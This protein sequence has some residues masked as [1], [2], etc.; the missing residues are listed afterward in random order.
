MFLTMTQDST[1]KKL[2]YCS[3]T[4]ALSQ[5]SSEIWVGIPACLIA[6]LNTSGLMFYFLTAILDT[7]ALRSK[8]PILVSLPVQ[9]SHMSHRY[10]RAF[11]SLQICE[12][13]KKEK[14]V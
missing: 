14:N 7:S 6:G 12:F 13:W 4:F 9:L 2:N 5:D 1:S 3:M 11:L 8:Q 10:H